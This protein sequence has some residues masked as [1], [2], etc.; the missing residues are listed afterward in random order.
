MKAQWGCRA[1]PSEKFFSES[2]ESTVT[3]FGIKRVYNKVYLSNLHLDFF[4]VVYNGTW[5]SVQIKLEVAE[6]CL[7]AYDKA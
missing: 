5:P 7:A 2:T 1:C 3:E 6:S 4:S